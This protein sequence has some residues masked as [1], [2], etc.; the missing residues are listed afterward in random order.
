MKTKAY[1]L[2]KKPNTFYADQFGSINVLKGYIPMGQEIKNKLENITNRPGIYQYL[3]SKNEIIYIGKAKNLKKRISS[4][5][6][7]SSL[8]NRIQRMGCNC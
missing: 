1:V 4:Y 8:S 3:N 5:K 2:S 7:S 6:N